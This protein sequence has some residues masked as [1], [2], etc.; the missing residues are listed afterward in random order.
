MTVALPRELKI[1]GTTRPQDAR[2]LNGTEVDYCGIVVNAAF[3]PRSVS[4]ARAQEIAE[5]TSCKTVVLLCNPSLALC[6]QVVAALQPC[7]LQLQCTESP[8]LLAEMRRQ[9]SVEIWKT[10]HLPWLDSQASPQVYLEAGA[11]RLLFDAQVMRDGRI[12]YGGTGVTADWGLVKE[13]MAALPDVPCFLAGGIRS[14]NLRKAVEATAPFGVDLCS[15]VESQ[16]GCRDP[17]LLANLLAEW[18]TLHGCA[19]GIA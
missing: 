12:R 8:N 11:D 14:R 17:L 9:L 19:G 4:L 10:I 5:A 15:G 6:R 7:A 2:L 3:S 18:R 16:V 1:C 13:Q